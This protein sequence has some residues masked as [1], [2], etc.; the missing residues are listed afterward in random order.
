[1]LRWH[2]ADGRT[3][4]SGSPC[5]QVILKTRQARGRSGGWAGRMMGS[6]TGCRKMSPKGAAPWYR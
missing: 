1:M 3:E 2:W 5:V 6:A 4:N